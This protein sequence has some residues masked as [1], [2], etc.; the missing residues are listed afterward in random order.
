M[1]NEKRES[2]PRRSFP[3]V[4]LRMNSPAPLFACQGK[5]RQEKTDEEERGESPS[6]GKG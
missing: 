2:L 6:R 4:V 1:K 3:F 5:S